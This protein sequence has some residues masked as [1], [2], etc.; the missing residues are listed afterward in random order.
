MCGPSKKVGKIEKDDSAAIFALG[1][2]AS[3]LTVVKFND[4]EAKMQ[5]DTYSEVTLIPKK[6]WVVQL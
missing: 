2:D 6:Y 1:S 5:V 4:Y 3:S